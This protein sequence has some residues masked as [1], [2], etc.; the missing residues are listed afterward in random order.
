MAV[1][2]DNGATG[3]AAFAR[4]GSRHYRVTHEV[5]LT[6][7]ERNPFSRI[8]VVVPAPA[9][10]PHQRVLGTPT[11]QVA[12]FRAKPLPLGTKNPQFSPAYSRPFDR[13]VVKVDLK[14][15]TVRREL[16]VLLFYEVEAWNLVFDLPKVRQ[17]ELR[18]LAGAIP[19]VAIYLRPETL[20]ESE[21]PEIRAALAEAFPEGLDDKAP[22]YDVA[23][24]IYQWVLTHSTYQLNSERG[25]LSKLWGALDLLRTGRGECS[26][27][28]ALFVALCR[29]AGI[30]ARSQVGFWTEKESSPHVW[31]EFHVPGIGWIPVD[32]ASG[33]RAG[34]DPARWF[35]NLPDLNRRITVTCAFDH[36]V[37]DLKLDYLQDFAYRFWYDGKPAALQARC[38]FLAE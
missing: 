27:Y 13:P 15:P 2:A 36:R 3:P 22:A 24:T 10:L 32:P 11:V 1:G 28:S 19:S 34:N 5:T 7:V 23:W 31:A 4:G 21:H 8:V 26:D 30:P 18:Q 35:G 25:R 17:V 14:R 16:R 6:P 9:D 37:A 12:P 20:V 29:A 33:D 38:R